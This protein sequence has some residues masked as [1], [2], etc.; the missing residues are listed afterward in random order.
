[1]LLPLCAALSLGA[2]Q[3]RIPTLD[4]LLLVK[5]VSGA[6]ISPDGKWVAY[7]IA[8]T[9]FKLD[10]FVTHIWLVNTGTGENLQLTRGDKS[11]SSFRWSPDGKWIAF[12]SGRAGDKD[13]IFVIRPDGG[14]AVQLTKCETDAS[15]PVWSPN[16]KS[17]AF[18]ATE[19]QPQALKDRKEHYG[20]FDVVR[21]EYGYWKCWSSASS[22]ARIPGCGSRRW[23]L[24]RSLPGSCA[25]TGATSRASSPFCSTALPRSGTWSKFARLNGRAARPSR[26]RNRRRRPAAPSLPRPLKN[27]NDAIS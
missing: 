18:T 2:D 27:L 1:M 11:D 25:A 3:P 12:T 22:L 16:S 26:R 8:E 17:I 13:Q 10:A 5:S 6:Q 9:D 4:D 7:G 21:E 24:C 20:D 14:E 23:R 15:G 19:P